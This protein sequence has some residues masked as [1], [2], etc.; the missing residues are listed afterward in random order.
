VI[1]DIVRENQ[2]RGVPKEAIDKQ[3]E[4]IYSVASNSAK[5]RVKVSFLL[6]RIA[7]KEGIKVDDR[8]M[9]QRIFTI[10]QQNQ[11]KPE[12][13]IKQLKERDGI[14]EIHEQILTAKTLDF[15]ELHAQVEEVQPAPAQP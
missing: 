2:Q 3:K 11:I 14:A 12:K 7:Q 13:L 15:L 8:E 1:Y 10:A 6:G 5:D 9:S 4:E